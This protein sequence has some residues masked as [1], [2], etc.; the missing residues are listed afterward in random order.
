M[1]TVVCA[2]DDAVRPGSG[3]SAT[4]RVATPPPASRAR[5][6]GRADARA[7][8]VTRCAVPVTK[9]ASVITHR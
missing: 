1:A 4:R 2:T 9:S 5:P 7:Q 8:A 3:S 6:A